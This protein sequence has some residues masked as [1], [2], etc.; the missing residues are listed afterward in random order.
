VLL[1]PDKDADGLSAGLV[2]HKTLC[3]LGI[4]PADIHVHVL[5]KG[6]NVHSSSEIATMEALVE[7]HDIER[8]IVLDQGSRPGAILR[9]LKG[10]G[11]AGLMVIDHHQ[12][13]EVCR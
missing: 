1:V 9:N 6:T 7:Q 13:K 5:S 3:L 8:A 11:L 4:D 2:L 12:S 10:V